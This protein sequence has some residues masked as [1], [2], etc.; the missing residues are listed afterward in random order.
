MQMAFLIR[1]GQ[2]QSINLIRA[3]SNHSS[4]NHATSTDPRRPDD[5]SSGALGIQ[6]RCQ[7]RL[8]QP[9]L[10]SLV[11]STGVDTADNRPSL[12]NHLQNGVMAALPQ[13]LPPELADYHISRARCSQAAK[14]ARRKQKRA[15]KAEGES[16]DVEAEA[17][18][19]GE[20]SHDADAI[21]PRPEIL[22]HL[23]LGLNETIRALEQSIGDLRLRMALLAEGVDPA[24]P[25]LLPAAPDPTPTP[26]V[27]GREAGAITFL[28]VPHTS[29][30]P[31]S[32]VD[33]L[34]TYCATYNTLLRQ[35]TTLVR[36]TPRRGGG[37]GR[38]IRIVP[39]GKREAD[40]AAAAGLRRVT[41]VCVRASHPA[42]P[43]L[44]RLLKSALAP[45]RHSMTLPWP[46]LKLAV[47]G[48]GDAAVAGGV[49]AG[50]Q[51]EG[52]DKDGAQGEEAKPP[53][54]IAYAPLHIKALHT[55]APLDNNARKAKRLTEVRQKRAEAK[56]QR[57]ARRKDLE[58]KVRADVDK[59]SMGRAQR[60]AAKAEKLAEKR[61]SKA[62]LAA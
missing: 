34:P 17:P 6:G 43:V 38:E 9:V 53:A 59:A 32:L 44:D 8:R 48:G 24:L 55:T 14:R 33:P 37:L 40:I 2:S 3:I 7:A 18:R 27:E 19:T 12:P 10:Y 16:M 54:Q 13:I 21:P 47:H 41:S 50:V 29:V 51:K 60:R 42:A 62:T 45:P 4:H 31:L 22:D 15:V 11:S 46:T 57:K 61:E 5:P 35:A 49:K 25:A 30:S 39:L 26:A 1:C 56:V 20:S 23:V 28:L 58:R 36:G 52:A